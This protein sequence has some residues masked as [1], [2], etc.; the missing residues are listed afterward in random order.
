[1]INIAREVC[2]SNAQKMSVSFSFMS[3]E[4]VNI[5]FRHEL[6]SISHVLPPVALIIMCP[7]S[8]QGFIT[9]L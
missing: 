6:L 5:P 2:C 8:S 3:Y 9:P 4:L 7:K 1:M